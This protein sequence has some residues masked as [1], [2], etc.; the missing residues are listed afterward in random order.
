MYNCHGISFFDG[1][2]IHNASVDGLLSLN[3]ENGIVTKLFIGSKEP[4]AYVAVH[5][6]KIFCTHTGCPSVQCYNAD[7]S[8]AW[9]FKDKSM[10]G[11]RGIAVD[12]NGIVY[13]ANQDGGN[14]I[15]IKQDGSDHKIIKIDSIP[16]PRSKI[17]ILETPIYSIKNWNKKQGHKNPD[18]F[19]E[20][21]IELERQLYT[22]NGRIRE[23]NKRIGSHSPEFSSDISN[24]SKYHCGKDR[25]LKTTRNYEFG[26][27]QDGIHPGELLAK[28]WL[29]KISEQAKRDCWESVHK[30]PLK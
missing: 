30:P 29:K 28:N 17:T 2:L 21:D 25:K 13:V 7:K 14:I 15:I 24:T 18:T 3:L 19:E 11:P 6:G 20:Q 1:D 9:E 8:L 26:L 4:D 23:I 10:K 22:L 5:D 16:T 12:E 27:Y